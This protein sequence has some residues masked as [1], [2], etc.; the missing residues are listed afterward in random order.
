M[1]TALLP[2]PR[3]DDHQLHVWLHPSFYPHPALYSA[4]GLGGK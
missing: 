1:K 4:G 2:S 3:F